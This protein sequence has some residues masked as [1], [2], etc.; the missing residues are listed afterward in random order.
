MY[1]PY[2]D[3]VGAS[4]TSWDAEPGSCCQAVVSSMIDVF[5]SPRGAVIAL[6]NA[7]PV[8]DGAVLYSDDGQTFREMA[9]RGF[10]GSEEQ[11][12]LTFE[13]PL[14]RRQYELRRDH[15]VLRLGREKFYRAPKVWDSELHVLPLPPVRQPEYMFVAPDG[16]FLYVSDTVYRPSYDFWFF[17]GAPPVLSRVPVREVTRA[18]DGGTTFVKTDAGVLYVPTSWRPE[19]RPTWNGELLRKLDPSRFRVDES[20]MAA[21]VSRR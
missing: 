9:G 16:T 20:P 8:G 2:Y 7:M 1:A 4:S 10:A 6:R 15:D 14:D 13:D 17:V 18:R 5:R 11:Y 3:T 19:L 12:K 21:S